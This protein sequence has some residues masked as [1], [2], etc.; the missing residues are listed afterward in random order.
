MKKTTTYNLNMPDKTDKVNVDDLNQNAERIDNNMGMLLVN[1]NSKASIH[2]PEF[3]GE[4]K[5]PKIGT[6]NQYERIITIA[7]MND[8]LEVENLDEENQ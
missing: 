8:A 3:S 1:I 4:P 6:T 5:A 7:D 2:S